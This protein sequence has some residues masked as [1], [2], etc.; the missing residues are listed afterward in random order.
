MAIEEGTRILKLVDH[1]GNTLYVRED[2]SSE[3]DVPHQRRI[4]S[5]AELRE[6]KEAN[7]PEE[8]VRLRNLPVYYA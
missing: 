7:V 8:E 1:K 6:L 5:D 3:P 2:P 4:R